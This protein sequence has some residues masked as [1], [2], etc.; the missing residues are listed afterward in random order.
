M[1][2]FSRKYCLKSIENLEESNDGIYICEYLNEIF[3]LSKNL[4]KS[5]IL[6]GSVVP[7]TKYLTD[8]F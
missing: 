2:N 5:V 8:L 6:K 1:L 4:S 3:M 7:F